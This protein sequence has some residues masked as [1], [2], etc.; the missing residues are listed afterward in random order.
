[1]RRRCRLRRRPRRPQRRTAA[2]LESWNADPFEATIDDPADGRPRELV[3]TGS[4]IVAGLFNAMYDDELIPVLPSLLAPSWRATRS[5]T[6]SSSN[7]PPT[8]S[9]S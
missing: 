8:A 6:S 3:I 2:L 5:P 1:M 9:T 7:W 4:D